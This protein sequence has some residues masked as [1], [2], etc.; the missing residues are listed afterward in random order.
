MSTT[1]TQVTIVTNHGNPHVH[2]AGCGDLANRHKYP[3]LD[4]EAAT[5]SATTLREVI[6]YEWG[7]VIEQDTLDAD[8]AA[9]DTEWRNYTDLVTVY[10]CAAHL[11]A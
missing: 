3:H 9:R 7:D 10:P 8:Q 5:I 6:E 2:A 1:T 11:A 4:I